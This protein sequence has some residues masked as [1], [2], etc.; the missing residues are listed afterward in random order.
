MNICFDVD[1]CLLNKKGP[2]KAN[3]ALVK[4]L[5]KSHKVYLWSGNGY[6]HAYDVAYTLNLLDY[7][8]GVLNKYSTFVPDIAFD[9]QEIDLG[10]INIQI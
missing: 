6:T 1:D 2:I 7:L 3:V 8:S 10:K 5:S 4:I 9:N